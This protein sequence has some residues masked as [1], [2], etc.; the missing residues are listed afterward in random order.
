MVE[1]NGFTPNLTGQIQW[2]YTQFDQ[3][4]LTGQIGGKSIEIDA[5]R[6]GCKFIACFRS[7]W[8]YTQFDRALITGQIG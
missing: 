7:Q 4:N 2:I 1:F 3:S 8:I 6:F 5:G